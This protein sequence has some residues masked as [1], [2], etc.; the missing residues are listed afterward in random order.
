MLYMCEVHRIQQF[1]DI[2]MTALQIPIATKVRDL[3]QSHATTVAITQHD[4]TRVDSNRVINCMSV[5]KPVSVQLQHKTNDILIQKSK[6]LS[7]NSVQMSSC[8]T[9]SMQKQKCQLVILMC[10]QKFPGQLAA[11]KVV[12]TWNKILLK[13]IK[14]GYL[15][16]TIQM[17]KQFGQHQY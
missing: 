17:Q 8:F 6:M 5:L 10:N 16:W 9:I 3:H 1:V 11:S 4:T 2:G 15:Y 12:K 14:G 7:M 13:N